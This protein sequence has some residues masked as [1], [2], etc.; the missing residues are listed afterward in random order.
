MSS[1]FT[2]SRL[3]DDLGDLKSRLNDQ[4]S[5]LDREYRFYENRYQDIRRRLFDHSPL[6]PSWWTSITND[7]DRF[8][9]RLDVGHFDPD[10]IEVKTVDNLVVIHGKHGDRTDELGVISR[11]FTRKCALPKEVKPETVKCSITSDGFLI[12]EAPK[13]PEKPPANE[14]VVPIT[15][16][17]TFSTEDGPATKDVTTS[18][19][20]TKTTTATGTEAR[21][22][23]SMTTTTMSKSI[24]KNGMSSGY[25]VGTGAISK[26]K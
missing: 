7:S 26:I 9:L 22:S 17:D 16:L 5:R 1:I 12:V 13:R 18:T 11:E 10:D 4:Y 2:S 3:S 19:S 15:V 14:R 20:S 23:S 6:K 8:C 25:P 21:T 24:L